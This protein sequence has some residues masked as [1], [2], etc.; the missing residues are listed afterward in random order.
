MAIH[1]LRDG[2]GRINCFS[3]CCPPCFSINQPSKQIRCCTISCETK[4]RHC[5]TKYLGR[6]RFL[7][8]VCCG[9]WNKVRDGLEMELGFQRWKR[10]TQYTLLLTSKCISY[11]AFTPGHMSPGN[12]CPGRATSI[13]IHIC[14]RTHVAGYM[15]LV[16]DTCGLYLSDIITIH[17]CHSRFVSLSIQQQTGNK[18]ATIPETCRRQ[19]VDTT[20]IRK[21]VSWCKC[22]IKVW[23]RPVFRGGTM[24]LCQ[25]PSAPK[26]PRPALRHLLII[27][28]FA[29]MHV[30]RVD[31]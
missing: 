14:R 2:G 25:E 28:D 12:M 5:A 4:R 6:L 11:A 27:R 23:P 18:L 7:S 22:G 8:A 31:I 1:K 16:R 13:R 17:L 9:V 15:L 3:R 20:C 19:Q 29:L 10:I 21:H 24:A 26:R 30:G